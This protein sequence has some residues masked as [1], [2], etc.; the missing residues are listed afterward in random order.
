MPLIDQD[1]AKAIERAQETI[2]L[3]KELY[4]IKWLD[5]MR[6]KL[7]LLN[8]K[9][10]D[11]QLITDFLEWMK[12]NETDYTNTFR[13][14]S[15]LKKPSGKLYDCEDFSIWHKYWQA[16]F[17]KNKDNQLAA[18]KVMKENNPAIIPRNHNVEAALNSAVQGDLSVFQNLLEVLKKPYEETEKLKPYQSPP[19]PSDQV[20][21]TFCGT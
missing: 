2:D 4:Q 1:Q 12:V 16:S 17:A 3:F 7:G 19:E 11:E 15:Q 5:M 20:Y 14:L 13:D 21:Q 8:S 6:L 18:L 10:G 9:P